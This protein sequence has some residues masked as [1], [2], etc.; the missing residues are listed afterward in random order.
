MDL[1]KKLVV[2]ERELERLQSKSSW[3]RST[4]S[5]SSDRTFGVAS[6]SN[7]FRMNSVTS[8]LGAPPAWELFSLPLSRPP[9]NTRA[10]PKSRRRGGA[11]AA[12]MPEWRA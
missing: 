7:S 10:E 9:S 2:M 4:K 12:A 8:T 5:R 6:P 1:L 3:S 11:V